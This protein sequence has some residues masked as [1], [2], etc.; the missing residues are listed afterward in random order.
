MRKFHQLK[1]PY[2][3]G[4]QVKLMLPEREFIKEVQPSEYPN[5]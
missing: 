4:K 2:D 1:G 5:S 3:Y